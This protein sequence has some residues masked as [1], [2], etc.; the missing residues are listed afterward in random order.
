MDKL[1]LEEL[2]LVKHVQRALADIQSDEV[3]TEKGD[4]FYGPPDDSLRAI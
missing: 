4:C 1:F 2:I 3:R